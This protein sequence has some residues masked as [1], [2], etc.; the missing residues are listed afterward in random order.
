M[1]SSLDK[2]VDL[3]QYWRM[4]WRRRG[5][6]LLCAVTT[7]CAA[8]VAL[9]FVP[10]EYE[11]QV[12]LMIEDTR[13]LS[14]SLR[15][16]MGG[17]NQEPTGSGSEGVRLGQVVG[18]IRSRPFLERVVRLLKMNE[19]PVIR[20]RA[21]ERARRQPE[22]SVDEMAV[23]MLVGN[24]QSRI[25]FSSPGSGLYNISVADYSAKNAQALARWISEL[26]VDVSSENSLDRL[27]AAH[28]FGVEQT[29]IYAEQLRRSE[30][31]LGNFRKSL[32]EQA[33][34]RQTVRSENLPRA[35]SMHDLVT[36]EVNQAR[37]RVAASADSV[38]SRHLARDY[39]DL[40]GEPR[41]RDLAGRLSSALKDELIRGL[42]AP[43]QT[44]GWPPTGSYPVLRVWLLQEIERQAA[45]L[46]PEAGSEATSLAARS[47]FARI[48]LDVLEHGAELLGG[49]IASSR[50]HAQ[51]GPEDD[52]ELTRLAAEVESNR[53]LL[54]SFQG[55]LVASD[56]SQAVEMTS[57]GLKME[58]LDPANLPLTPSRPDKT[59]ILLASLF[60]GPLIG[61]GIAFMSETLDPTLRSL[62]DFARIMPEP[63]LGTTPLL[64]RLPMRGG[65]LRRH[66]IPV[67]VAG[68]LLLATFALVARTTMLN[69]LAAMGRPVQMA[70]P[71]ESLHESR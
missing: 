10:K 66:W 6:V 14:A 50:R 15:S 34:A 1:S 60:L 21:Q 23:R 5:L 20:A 39:A 45:G 64:T 41:I 2:T 33:Q 57:L 25:R 46:H 30:E 63:V 17:I 27:R 53:K 28:E 11:S 7:I 52:I 8:V 47:V 42:D 19:D 71:K 40:A 16:V 29:K 3:K 54:E 12:T 26:F 13:S 49:A 68:V 9:I 44:G 70:E 65:W 38:S 37:E 58:I 51:S 69:N 61:V 55:Q 22:L 56:V 31:K 48:D 18:R 24:L 62:E 43:G 67:G 32:V 35:E 4:I 59:K 36:V